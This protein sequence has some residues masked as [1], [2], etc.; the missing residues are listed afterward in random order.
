MSGSKKREGVK[1]DARGRIL[2]PHDKMRW[3]CRECGGGAFCQHGKWRQSCIECGGSQICEHNYYRTSCKQCRNL[4]GSAICEH[5]VVRYQCVKCHGKGICEHNRQRSA[6]KDCDGY[7]LCEH[8][9]R[10]DKCRICGG[11]KVWAKNMFNNL[12][13]RAKKSDIPFDLDVPWIEER[14]K[15]GCP[16]FKSPF[17]LETPHVGDFSATVDKFIP[18]LGYIKTNCFIISGIANRIKNSATT[19]QVKAVLNWMESVEL[20]KE[21]DDTFIHGSHNNSEVRSLIGDTVSS[22]SIL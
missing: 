2:C 22:F 11:F 10:A 15:Q 14:L 6:C 8:K 20:G 13:C 17:K 16:V 5:N 7:Q 21:K 1:R 9:F 18:K 19:E 4:D 12:K 3:K